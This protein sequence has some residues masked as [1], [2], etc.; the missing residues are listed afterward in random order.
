MTLVKSLNSTC[1]RWLVAL[2]TPCKSACLNYVGVTTI[3]RLDQSH[4]DPSELPAYEHAPVKRL[5]NLF[6]FIS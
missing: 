6:F 3:E 5:Y 2:L 1:K 4:I